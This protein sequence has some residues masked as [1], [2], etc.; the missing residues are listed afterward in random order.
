MTTI[1]EPSKTSLTISPNE[2]GRIGREADGLLLMMVQGVAAS[3]ELH[4]LPKE[5]VQTKG[6][7]LVYVHAP[8]GGSYK[9][10][11]RWAET[12]V[13]MTTWWLPVDWKNP[14]QAAMQDGAARWV[15]EQA[16]AEINENR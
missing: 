5:S 15:L 3:H 16:I 2:I 4:Y 1:M 8:E 11:K 7:V 10:L 12:S 6:D 14:E 9:G 13:A